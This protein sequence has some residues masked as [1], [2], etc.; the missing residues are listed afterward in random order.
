[1]VP[2]W[3]PIKIRHLLFRV[4]KKGSLTSTHIVVSVF[5]SIIPIYNPNNIVVS[6]FF[7][8]IPIYNPDNI[9]VSVFFSIIPIC[10][11]IQ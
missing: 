10:N 7:S 2:F 3:V 6:V 9:V 4:P 11:P 8:I 1:M 5:F